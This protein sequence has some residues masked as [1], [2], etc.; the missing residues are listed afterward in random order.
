[1][2]NDIIKNIIEDEDLIDS[3]M[4]D[5]DDFTSN[6][7][8]IESIIE[9]DNNID[10]LVIKG[11]N[12]YYQESLYTTNLYTDKDLK[13]FIKGTEKIVRTSDDYRKYIGYLKND[14]SL[15]SCAFLNHVNDESV[16]I[17]MHHYPFTL[18]DI[19]NIVME[20]QIRTEKMTTFS[21]AKE[22]MKIHFDNMIGLIPLSKTV[23]DLAHSGEIFIN[24]KQVFGDYNKFIEE[25]YKYIPVNLMNNYNKLIDM[26]IADIPYSEN[27][28]LKLR[29]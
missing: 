6:I 22:V 27:D 7:G 16:D 10:N 20:K 12:S 1:M 24:L 8:N 25:Y 17:E 15:T 13:N 4:G 11:S 5:I 14:L 19:C 28:I 23:H 2:S 18:Y 9:K 29:R 3:I 26:S 21:V